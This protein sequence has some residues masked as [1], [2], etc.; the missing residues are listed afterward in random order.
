[1]L[2]KLFQANHYDPLSRPVLEVNESVAVQLGIVVTKV[3]EVVSNDMFHVAR[4]D[5]R[6]RPRKLASE[7]IQYDEY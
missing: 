1:M 6:V 5:A 7:A 3:I 4:L 2:K